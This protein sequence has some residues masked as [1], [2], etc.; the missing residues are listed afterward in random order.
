L[1]S[2]WTTGFEEPE[3]V[4]LI[5]ALEATDLGNIQR[6]RIL[7]AGVKKAGEQLIK[8]AEP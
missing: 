3:T 8:T 4:R 6:V 7:D 2:P 1:A 5:L